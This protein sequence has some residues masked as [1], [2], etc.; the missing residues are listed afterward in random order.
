LN[1]FQCADLVT[2]LFK[3][4]YCTGRDSCLDPSASLMPDRH[5]AYSI[6]A[7]SLS[8]YCEILTTDARAAQS[9]QQARHSLL[10]HLSFCGPG[11]L[12][13]P[14]ALNTEARPRR[15]SSTETHQ[16]HH[17]VNSVQSSR[18]RAAVTH[19]PTTTLVL[20]R[21]PLSSALPAG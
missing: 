8:N 12:A 4:P 11:W 7:M 15:H 18:L 2:T 3:P 16:W 5:E 17:T 21:K 6:Y 20:R 1:R 10:Q 14:R 19:Q 9:L 13:S